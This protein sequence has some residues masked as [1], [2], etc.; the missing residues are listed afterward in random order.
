MRREMGKPRQQP[1][2]GGS[3]ADHCTDVAEIDNFPPLLRPSSFGDRMDD[4]SHCG[5]VRSLPGEEAFGEPAGV[6]P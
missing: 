2:S 1:K 5:I 6:E 3:L 4:S